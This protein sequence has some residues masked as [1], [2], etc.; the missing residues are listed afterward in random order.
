MTHWAKRPSDRR[1]CR[2]RRQAPRR[3][4]AGGGWL[5][6]PSPS[7]GHQPAPL[8]PVVLRHDGHAGA[9]QGVH[10]ADRP[11]ARERRQEAGRGLAGVPGLRGQLRVDAARVASRVA[12]IVLDLLSLEYHETIMAGAGNA[13]RGGSRAR[14]RRTRP[15]S[16]SCII[17]GAIPRAEGGVYCTIG[18]QTA[19]DIAPE[20]TAERGPHDRRRRL[21]LGRRLHHP[22]SHRAPAASGRGRPQGPDQPR[23]L[24]AQ[25]REHRG[26]DRP[27]PDLRRGCPR[28]TSTTAPSSPMAT[29]STTSASGAPTST[30]A[31]TWRS[32]ATRA[33]AT[34]WCLYKM[35]CKGPQATFNCP[36]VRW[37][38][39]TSWPIGAGHGCVACASPRF[40][41]RMSPFYD[42]LP[43]VKLIGVDTTAQTI[44]LVAIGGVAVAHRRPRRRRRWSGGDRRRKAA[45]AADGTVVPAAGDQ[46]GPAT[47][48]PTPPVRPELSEVRRCRSIVIDPVTRIEGHLRIEAKVD[49]GK[50]TEAWSSG[51]MFRGMELILRGKDPRE[52]WLWA[53]RI[54]GVCTTVHAHASVNAVE[55]AL[56][57][58]IPEN[59][60]LIRNLIAGAQHIQDH[61]I[62]F[63]HLHALDWVDVSGC[64]QGGSG[65]RPPTSPQSISPWPS[66]RRRRTSRGPG[67]RQEAR[68][69]RPAQPVRQRLLGPPGLQA[70]ARSR[71]D[72]GRPLPRGARVAAG[73]HP[74]PRGPRRQEPAPPDVPRR[75]H[76]ERRSTRPRRTSSTPS[77]S[78]SSRSGSSTMREF[79]EQVYIPDV[80]AVASFYPEWASIG[81]GHRNYLSYGCAPGRGPDDDSKFSVP[82]PGSSWAATSARSSRSTRRRSPSRSPAPTTT[83][84]TAATTPLHP[85]DGRD[86]PEVQRARRRRTRT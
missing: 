9:P 63:Y 69:L 38:D 37:N 41:D 30:P 13:G 32:G 78:R 66:S 1:L 7:T 20:V 64:P 17:E 51:T 11:G 36:I 4:D 53:Q 50:V 31:A 34:G 85:C 22:G 57:I 55:D 33:T 21:R 47:P 52:A 84:R 12:D 79:V 14:P 56:G 28:S 67:A 74:R 23:R 80:K 81:A 46:A 42:R 10:A 26:G 54:C 48:R 24:P 25:Q 82:P 40:W 27:L 72:G 19:L 65:R 86:E 68:R 15:A 8:P 61:V 18:G 45:L 75:R 62:H 71:P 43:N 59:A 76:G 70:P 3:D 5:S 6:T 39:G 49:G 16:T 73:R 77:G 60:R 2:P 35:G 44:G 58:E 29:S 83:T